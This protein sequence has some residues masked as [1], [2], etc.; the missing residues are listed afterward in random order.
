[1]SATT[2]QSPV[3]PK[4]ISLRRK[5]VEMANGFFVQLATRP[6]FRYH[7]DRNVHVLCLKEPG[8]IFDYQ[9]MK[10]DPLLQPVKGQSAVIEVVC[11]RLNENCL[12]LMSGNLESLKMFLW[13]HR[14]RGNT[15]PPTE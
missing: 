7:C 13:R 9:A 14:A 15:I 4:S 2:I 1:M 6:G 8:Q 5:T 10:N 11:D 12:Y 3:V